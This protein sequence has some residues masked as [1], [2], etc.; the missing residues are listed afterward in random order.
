MKNNLHALDKYFAALSKRLG[1][2]SD[3]Q[4][5]F[6]GPRGM[7]GYLNRVPILLLGRTGRT[8]CLAAF[9]FAKF[10]LRLRRQS[11]FKGLAIYLKVS[12]TCLIKAVAGSPIKGVASSLG[13]RVAVTKSGLP[14][15]IPQV[16]RKMILAGDGRAIR[17]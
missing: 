10:A 5:A 15:L 13:H 16:Q 14:K 1:C 11:G 3:W 12:A 17:V 2:T 8:W 9:A 4:R 6:M 7:M